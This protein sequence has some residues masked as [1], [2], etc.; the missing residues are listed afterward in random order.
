M[1]QARK[2]LAP[3]AVIGVMAGGLLATTT[4]AQ[5]ADPVEVNILGINDFHGRIQANGAEAGAAVLAGAVDQI[6]GEHP[7][8][9]F[10]AAGDLIGA[11]SFESFIAQ[12]KPTIDALNA[13]GLEVSAAGNHEF[14]QGYRDLV[15][16]VMAP[17]DAETNPYGGA[18]WEYLAANVKMKDT[19]NP[20][21]DPTYVK[22]VDGVEVG[23]VG[24]V[25]EHLPELVSPGGISEI[26]VTD[27]VSAV[28]TEADKLKAEGVDL[29]VMLVH[30]G[31]PST[32]CETMDDDPASDFGSI[33]TGVNANVDAIVS[34]HTHLAYDCKFPVAEWA[35]RAV[36]ER[37]VVSA[38][39]YGMNLNQLTFTV[40]PDTGV[41][42]V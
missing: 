16:R 15:D 18:E 3:I 33:V 19:G 4:P 5:A 40:D 29:V 6:R 8:T 32:T 30:E 24:A 20:A 31:A 23:F 12:D 27:I 21:L 37:P 39:Q 41:T 28:N 9:I 11:S 26:Q 35:G 42:G 13:A 36:T 38:G 25:T 7:N 10:A 2:R 34:G 14:D 22:S 17:Y 1:S